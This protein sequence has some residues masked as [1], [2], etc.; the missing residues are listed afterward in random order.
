[1]LGR[2]FKYLM[3]RDLRDLI[4]CLYKQMTRMLL[5]NDPAPHTT[6]PAAT[7]SFVPSSIKIKLPV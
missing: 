4:I 3:F 7:V 1:M 6:I 2:S 5:T